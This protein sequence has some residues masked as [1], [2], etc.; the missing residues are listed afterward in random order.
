MQVML[1]TPSGSDEAGRGTT[2]TGRGQELRVFVDRGKAKLRVL[3]LRGGEGLQGHQVQ[4]DTAVEQSRHR[5]GQLA[6]RQKPDRVRQGHGGADCRCGNGRVC[7]AERSGKRTRDFT[8]ADGSAESVVP[9]PRREH[10]RP[11]PSKLV[12]FL[13]QQDTQEEVVVDDDIHR[14]RSSEVGFVGG[15]SGGELGIAA[16]PFDRLAEEGS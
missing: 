7:P 14:V 4:A 2:S 5:P 11:G 6:K 12:W 13:I 1:S 8:A 9:Q 15:H 10:L 16:G 3:V